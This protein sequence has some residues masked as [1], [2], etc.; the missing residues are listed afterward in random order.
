MLNILGERNPMF[1]LFSLNE[2]FKY[3]MLNI[4]RDVSLYINVEHRQGRSSL[5]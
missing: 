2:N 4:D 3:I 1:K 5:Y